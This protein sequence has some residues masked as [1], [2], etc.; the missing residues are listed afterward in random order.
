MVV[1]VMRKLNIGILITLM[2]I[3]EKGK[4]EKSFPYQ[5]L[6]QEEKQ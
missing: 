6:H 5:H 3:K 2:N 1:W 4:G